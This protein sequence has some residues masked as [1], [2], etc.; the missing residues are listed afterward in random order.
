MEIT[1]F[2]PADFRV[3][4]VPGFAER[5]A[6]LRAEVRPKL[7]ILGQALAGPLSRAAGGAVFPHVA[8]HARR[9]V[10]PPD[11]TWV[12]F[13]PHRRG[14]KS[15]AHFKIAVS[16]HGVRFLFEIGPEHAAKPA[17]ARAWAREAGRLRRGLVRARDLAWFRNEH[18]EEPAAALVDLDAT[19]FARLGEA[20][21]RTRDGQ[22]VLGRRFTETAAARWKPVDYERT[23]RET[24]TALAACFRLGRGQP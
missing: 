21:V 7:E 18:D 23:A 2:V 13:G 1:P 14:Y 5:M 20:V 11:D 22:L 17:F 16:R 19:A 15:A 3:F 8:R 6:R 12:A 10:N 9:T 24:F 4:D